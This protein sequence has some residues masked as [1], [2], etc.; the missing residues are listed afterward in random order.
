M[1][2]WTTPSVEDTLACWDTGCEE[3]L[4]GSCTSTQKKKKRNTPSGGAVLM[5]LDCGVR[6][7]SEGVTSRPNMMA[8]KA[9]E[10]WVMQEL[11]E[12]T[13][14]L[15]EETTARLMAG[16]VVRLERTMTAGDEKAHLKRCYGA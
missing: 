11:Q 10:S 8:G 14:R 4:M 16:D 9:W 1:H 3:A 7:R 15:K 12:S 6:L 2:T 5:R 13:D